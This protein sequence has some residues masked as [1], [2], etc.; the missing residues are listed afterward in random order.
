MPGLRIRRFERRSRFALH[1]PTAAWI[2]PLFRAGRD[3]ET[4]FTRIEPALKRVEIGRTTCLSSA[5]LAASANR[6]ISHGCKAK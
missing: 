5:R 6:L 1:S 4:S 2:P 3:L